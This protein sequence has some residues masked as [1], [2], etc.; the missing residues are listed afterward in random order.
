MS[1][2]FARSWSFDFIDPTPIPRLTA[3]FILGEVD[4]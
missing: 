3:A 2:T 1:L 4:T